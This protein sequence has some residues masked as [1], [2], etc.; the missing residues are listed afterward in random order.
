MKTLTLGLFLF[1]TLSD[2]TI[3]PTVFADENEWNDGK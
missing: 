2:V 3:I 1:L